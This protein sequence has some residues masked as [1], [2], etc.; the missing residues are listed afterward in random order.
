[1][2]KLTIYRLYFTKSDCYNRAIKQTPRGVQVHDTGANNPYLKR[3]VQPDD[4]RLGVNTNNNSH[5]KPGGN[6]CASAYIGKLQDGTVAT[7]QALP[8]NYRCWLSGSCEKE[9]TDSSGAKKK[10]KNNANNL[11]YI[12]FEICRDNMSS[13]EYFDEA[14]R[15]QSVLLTAHLCMLI[16]TTPNAIITETPFGPAYSVMDHTSL[17]KVSCASNHSDI[18]EWLKVF[19]YT[20]SDYRAWVQ[21]AM[22]EGVEVTYIDAEV[23]PVDEPTL[24]KGDSGEKVK[25]MQQ[26]LINL[27]YLPAGSDDGKFGSKTEAAVKEFQKDQGLA[28]DGVCGKKTWKRLKEVNGIFDEN[29]NEDE[30]VPSTPD[31]DYIKVSKSDWDTLVKIINKYQAVG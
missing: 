31:T 11:G 12:G 20:F 13:K 5:N 29:T 25:E 15:G 4:G 22:D 24:R 14:V 26:Y 6:V 9:Y 18:G 8:W 7:Y 19:G 23:E 10:Y 2:R 21:A 27:N 1:M 17:N 16:G 3:W 28:D 30:I